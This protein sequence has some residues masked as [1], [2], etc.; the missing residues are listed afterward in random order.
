MERIPNPNNPDKSMAPNNNWL[1]SPEHFEYAKS[2][3]QSKSTDWSDLETWRKEQGPAPWDDAKWQATPESKSHFFDRVATTN[4]AVNSY[5][6]EDTPQQCIQSVIYAMTEPATIGA[7]VG[8]VTYA[9]LIIGA[10]N[11]PSDFV[12]KYPDLANIITLSGSAL[13]GAISGKL[14]NDAYENE[15]LSNAKHIKSERNQ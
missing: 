10:A 12:I 8:A 13:I 6:Q 4:R 15:K 2:K 7:A 3:H 5:L 1:G 9:T 11:D 14:V